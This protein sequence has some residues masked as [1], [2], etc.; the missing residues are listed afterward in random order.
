M[1]SSSSGSPLCVTQW[2]SLPSRDVGNLSNVSHRTSCLLNNVRMRV[3]TF[4]LKTIAEPLQSFVS[5]FFAV[6]QCYLMLVLARVLVIAHLM[7][8]VRNYGT[9]QCFAFSS[10]VLVW[11]SYFE[12]MYNM[13]CKNH[14]IKEYIISWYCETK[15]LAAERRVLMCVNLVLL[16]S[17]RLNI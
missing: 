2:R 3:R 6:I 17:C 15:V 12:T 11:A 1:V 14:L 10:G 9:S 8:L 4:L 5:P 16:H 13:F 7:V